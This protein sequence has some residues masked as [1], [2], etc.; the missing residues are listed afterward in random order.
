MGYFTWTDAR[1]EPVKKARTGDYPIKTKIPY[2][3]YAKVIC[4]DDSVIIE[5]HY[6]GYGEF[7]G[8]DIYDL[9][10]DWNRDYLEEIFDRLAAKEPK[11]WGWYLRNLAVMYQHHKENSAEFASEILTVANN[12]GPILITEWKRNIGITISCEY[13]D[14]K[15]L[16]FPIKITS[17][18]WNKTYA[19]LYPSAG[20][21]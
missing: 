12:H 9:V 17:T 16:P 19:E 1:Y 3:E 8:H 20:C 21:Q 5:K 14:N 18:K 2:G 6:D 4:P 10:V 11:H 13:E 7:D 15:A